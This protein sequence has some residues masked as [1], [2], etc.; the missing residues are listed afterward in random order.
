LPIFG[1]VVVAN[2]VPWFFMPRKTAGTTETSLVAADP[3]TGALVA[4]RDLGP[5]DLDDAV[6]TPSALWVSDE[7]GRRV[8][9]Y[10]FAALR[11]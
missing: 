9:R 11:Q 5:L 3:A 6:V 4:A 2:G 1:G 8:M 10:D 7:Q